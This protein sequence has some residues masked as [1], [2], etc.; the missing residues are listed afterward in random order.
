VLVQNVPAP[1]AIVTPGTSFKVKFKVLVQAP[2][3]VV[4]VAEPTPAVAPFP[5][6]VHEVKFVPGIVTPAGKI[7]LNVPDNPVVIAVLPLTHKAGVAGEKVFT[8]FTVIVTLLFE[9]QVPFVIVHL[10][11]LFPT[12]NPVRPELFELG[13]VIVPVPPNNDQFP[14]PTVGEFPAKVAVVAALQSI[15][16][17]P[18]FETVAGASTW[19][20][21]SELDE[22]A[23]LVIVHLKT[24]SLPFPT[25]PKPVIPELLVPGDVI[26]PL[27]LTSV[28]LPIPTVGLFPASVAEVALQSV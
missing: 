5:F 4:N 11:T 27:P 12:A 26:V 2:D 20:I 23:P 22:Q 17:V 14:V 25:K 16:V 19:I 24:L 3:V 10:N 9:L 15:C 6:I 1:F 18:G 21:T 8:G 7:E 13:V 28:Q